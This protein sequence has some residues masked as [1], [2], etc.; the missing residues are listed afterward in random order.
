MYLFQ[1]TS[2]KLEPL[3]GVFPEALPALPDRQVPGEQSDSSPTS[4]IITYDN[5]FKTLPAKC[6]HI[7]GF[8][9]FPFSF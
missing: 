6:Q 1:S 8:L 3:V 5:S 7:F 2:E 9:L 4:R